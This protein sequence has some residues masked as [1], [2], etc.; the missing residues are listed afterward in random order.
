MRDL[1]MHAEKTRTRVL[2]RTSIRLDVV[3]EQQQAE[4]RQRGEELIHLHPAVEDAFEKIASP[5]I[6]TR[7]FQFGAGLVR[8]VGGLA[9]VHQ[10]LADTE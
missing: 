2:A 6:R 9:E 5:G 8:W 10:K 1:Q 7:L 3:H 4:V